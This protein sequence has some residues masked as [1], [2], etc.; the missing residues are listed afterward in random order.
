M[1]NIIIGFTLMASVSACNSGTENNTTV[2]TTTTSDTIKNIQAEPVSY[3]ADSVMNGFIAYDANI[4]D[5][6]PAILIVPEWWGITDYVRNRARQLAE[7]GYVA[8][9]VDMYGN[10]KVAADPNEAMALSM[11]FYENP[12][13]ARQRFSAALNEVKKLPQTDSTKV[14][15][16]GYCF[17]GAQ[18]LNMARLGVDLDGVVS[19]H[20]GLKG[21]TPQNGMTKAAVLVCNGADDNFV[22]QE[23]I[24]LFKKQMDSVNAPFTFINY[25]D[26]KHAFTN[27]DAD[28]KAKQFK[29]PI[30]Y[31][32]AADSASWQDMKAFLNKIF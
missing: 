14:A 25:P 24:D 11:P 26:A 6:R 23:E 3:K 20:G 16:I 8:M 4:K 29:M 18:V 27:P 19:F 9:V 17:G 30:A 13:F 2:S 15:A 5:K 7:L 22:P 21:V 32:A 12:A 1:K 28:A 31:N 10:G